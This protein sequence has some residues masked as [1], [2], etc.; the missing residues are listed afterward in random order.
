LVYAWC[1]PARAIEH[2]HQNFDFSS[3]LDSGAASPDTRQI[4]GLDFVIYGSATDQLAIDNLSFATG[5]AT[6]E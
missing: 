3:F 1:S 5:P 4:V 6:G 2:F